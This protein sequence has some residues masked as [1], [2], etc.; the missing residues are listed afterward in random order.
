VVLAR[1]G[2]ALARFAIGETVRPDAVAAIAALR[3]AS[4]DAAI[5]TGDGAATAAG[6][7]DELGLITLGG[8]TPRDKADELAAIARSAGGPIAM[9]GDGINDAP[10]LAGIGPGFA[11]RSAAGVTRGLA[12]VSL[13][14]DELRLVPWTLALARETRRV[15]RANFVWSTAYNTLFVTMAATGVLR[16]VWAA[17][18]MVTSSV[19]VVG[20][21]LRLAAVP[22][23]DAAEAPPP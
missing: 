8:L 22:G 20:R 3:A 9:V 18:A 4:L 12:K 21:A 11:M 2:R 16:P 15:V 6:V 23:P 7:G 14:R 1:D 13:L 17:L 19:L 5:A 10:A